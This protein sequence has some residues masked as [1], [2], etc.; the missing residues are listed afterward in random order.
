MRDASLHVITFIL[1]HHHT[2]HVKKIEELHRLKLQYYNLRMCLMKMEAHPDQFSSGKE[3]RELHTLMNLALQ[4]LK[5]RI[6]ELEQ[7]AFV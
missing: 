3:I 2:Y 4:T 6:M 5:F 1:P 7:I